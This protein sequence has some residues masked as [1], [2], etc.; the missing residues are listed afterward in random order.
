MI[1][2]I[3]LNEYREINTKGGKRV[4]FKLD[5][6]VTY[7]N[8]LGSLRKVADVY[9]VLPQ[10][11][12]RV[13]SPTGVVRNINILT[14]QQKK[15]IEDYYLGARKEDFSLDDLSQ[16]LGRTKNFICRYAKSV[17]LT[18][19]NRPLNDAQ[20]Q[21]VRKPKWEQ[22]PHPRGFLGGKHSDEGREKIRAASVRMWNTAKTFGIGLMSEE[23]R[24][25]RSDAMV[26]RSRTLSSST[27]Y[28]R[29]KQGV[30]RDI[31]DMHFRSAWEA[32]YARY[33]N[34]LI[35]KGQIEKWEYE[36]DVFWFEAIKRGVRSYKP[37]FKI[38]ENGK[39][40]YVEVKGWMD[41]KSKTKIKRMRIYYP[42]VKVIVFDAK[43]Y[44]ELKSK[45][46]RI[47]EGWE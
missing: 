33:L 12:H 16:L 31:G 8:E 47:I 42:D 26:T 18:N 25:Q 23:R 36:A 30:R 40:Y 4:C 20:L 28:S 15:I 24:Q 2:P 11:I 22:R 7:Y 41:D 34:W 21:Q 5:E 10:T 38:W 17:G 46:S 29:A 44:K 45:M 27:S 32:N 6:M 37:D 3:S 9:G 39:V 1:K 14:D 35:T 13:L 19:R 43:Q